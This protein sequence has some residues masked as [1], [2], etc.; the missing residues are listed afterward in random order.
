M[1]DTQLPTVSQPTASTPTQL[2][3][4]AAPPPPDER[5]VALEAYRKKLKEYKEVEARLKTLR[6]E[7]RDLTKQHDKSENDVKSLQSVGQIVGE[8]LKQLTEDKFIV[9]ATN[10]PRYVVGCRRN[11]NKAALKQGT[12]VSLDMTTL[13]IM[14][15]VEAKLECDLLFVALVAIYRAKSIRWC[16]KCHTK[17]LATCRTQASAVSASKFDNCERC[18]VIFQSSCM[19]IAPSR[20]DCRAAVEESRAISTSGHYTAEG[21]PIVWTARHRQDTASARRRQAA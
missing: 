8:V 5:T 13:T 1:A 15:C 9:K 14:R 12:R 17:T 6:L 4:A 7:E 10:G 20:A 2:P 19:Q 21:L 3:A 16:T 18:A 11:L